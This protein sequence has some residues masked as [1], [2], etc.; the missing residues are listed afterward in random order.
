MTKAERTKQFIIEQAAPIYNEKGIAGTNVDDILEATKLTKGA[1]YSHF[2]N[3]DDLSIQ[4]AEY[5]LEKIASGT[6]QAIKKGKTAKEKIFAY[7]DF[8]AHPLQTYIKGGCPIFNFAVESDDNNTCLKSKVNQSL[9]KSQKYFASI[10]RDG[11]K[12][13]EFS[14]SLNP[15][16]FAFKMYASIEGAI[17]L[18]RM[19][20][21]EK[22]MQGLI[23][24]LK[25]ELNSYGV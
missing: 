6:D 16:A 22:P 19:M 9:L 13:R 18:C 17:V 12:A 24:A 1:I 5:L 4:V 25:S 8:N 21:N 23:D 10:L 20:N 7:L 14:P 2:K 3:K 15:E 11:I